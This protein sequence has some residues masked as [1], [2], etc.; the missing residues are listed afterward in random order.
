MILPWYDHRLRDLDLATGTAIWYHTGLPPAA[1]RYLLIRDAHA[2]FLPQ[3]LLST[4]ATLSPVQILA[5]FIRRW[6]IEPAF[7]HVRAYLGVETQR[8]WSDKA[9]ART[10]PAL[11]RLFSLVTVC[12]YTLITTDGLPLR[13]TA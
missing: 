2:Q 5:F 4:D 12:T 11:L 1:I 13:A 9:I 3:A 7:Q 8:Q 10:I 6:A